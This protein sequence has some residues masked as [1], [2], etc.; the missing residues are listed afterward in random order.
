MEA[1][2]WATS[3]MARG[4][5][6]ALLNDVFMKGHHLQS[7]KAPEDHVAPSEA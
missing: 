3:R 4:E 6:F 5:H 7:C 2:L 1:H